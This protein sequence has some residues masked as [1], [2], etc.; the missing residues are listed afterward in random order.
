MSSYN[1]L[2]ENN[3][4]L[5]NLEK[6]MLVMFFGLH[7]TPMTVR[8]V[9]TA[10]K[11]PIKAASER[12]ACAR[13][14]LL[15]YGK[16]QKDSEEMQTLLRFVKLEPDQVPAA[17]LA[18]RTPKK[19]VLVEPPPTP[20][21][22]PTLP[23]PPV[24]TLTAKDAPKPVP[25]S[26]VG[27]AANGGTY[28]NIL[29]N[30]R[31]GLG[32]KQHEL[33]TLAGLTQCAISEFERMKTPPLVASTGQW[34][35]N[36]LKLASTLGKPPAELW[37]TYV[38]RIIELHPQAAPEIPP[39]PEVEPSDETT[40]HS[41]H[42]AQTINPPQPTEATNLKALRVRL[43]YTSM[44]TAAKACSLRGATYAKL[45]RGEFKPFFV[46]RQPK[47]ASTVQWTA[48]ALRVA[49][50]FKTTC[51][52]VWPT[53]A[54]EILQLREQLARETPPAPVPAQ[55]AKDVAPM[56]E[57]A[58][59]VAVS[60]TSR[61]RVTFSID[62]DSWSIEMT[63]SKQ[64]MLCLDDG[65]KFLLHDF[66]GLTPNVG[67]TGSNHTIIKMGNGRTVDIEEL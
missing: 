31:V 51:E 23:A 49:K 43:G 30:L 32:L 58:K 1:R 10:L 29:Y 27:E 18:Y 26:P 63:P 5:T 9:A 53:S 48:A 67:P 66:N 52:A 41:T 46:Q 56:V 57:P 22:P 36:A 4:R 42:N 16:D 20:L 40:E 6:S 24:A 3:K 7:K 60:S 64:F 19:K 55:P 44:P 33:G 62:A 17:S 8:D 15:N 45:E 2:H 59:T 21:A 11:Q 50:S 14:K 37:P 39:A 54:Q 28:N 35:T 12:I 38:N 65:K 25:E 47:G 34:S 13:N 61:F